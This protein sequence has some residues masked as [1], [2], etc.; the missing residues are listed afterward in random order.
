M[1]ARSA[2]CAKIIMIAPSLVSLPGYREKA[3]SLH[4]G[5]GGRMGLML[6]G[7][8]V[9]RTPLGQPKP[10]KAQLYAWAVQDVADGSRI[11]VLSSDIL[12]GAGE[13][14][15]IPVNPRVKR[16]MV[17]NQEVLVD[18]VS[19]WAAGGAVAQEETDWQVPGHAAAAAPRSFAAVA[20]VLHDTMPKA[21][22]PSS[23]GSA[24]PL[25]PLQSKA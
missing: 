9:G 22:Q 10:G 24:A 13:I 19:F 14:V 17:N 2:L 8:L 15:E 1:L 6:K 5:K 20:P 18:A 12:G 7:A 4:L 16:K 23:N 3:R 25:Q 21:S 11:E